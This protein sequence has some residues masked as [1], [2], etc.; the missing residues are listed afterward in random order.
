[1]VK[2]KFSDKPL[3]LNFSKINRAIK[4]IQKENEQKERDKE[5][6]Q[7]LKELNIKQVLK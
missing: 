6:A 5:T 7:I 4:E 2:S 1:M 3:F